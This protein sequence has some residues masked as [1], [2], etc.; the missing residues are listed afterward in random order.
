MKVGSTPYSNIPSIYSKLASKHYSKPVRSTLSSFGN[1]ID[2]TIGNNEVTKDKK[3]VKVG[4]G[5][6]AASTDQQQKKQADL[7]DQIIVDKM[8]KAERQITAH[9]QAHKAVAGQYAGAIS[10]DYETG[11]DGRR[12]VVAGD[13]PINAPQGRTPE[14]TIRIMERVKRAALA[15][16]DPSAQDAAVAARAAQI[17]QAARSEMAKVSN[18]E[19]QKNYFISFPLKGEITKISDY[20]PYSQPIEEPDDEVETLEPGQKKRMG[21]LEKLTKGRQSQINQASLDL[22]SRTAIISEETNKSMGPNMVSYEKHK[23][24]VQEQ[25]NYSSRMFIILDVVA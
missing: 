5:N 17:Q 19:Y 9:E 11:P 10:Y 15:P 4:S 16:A 23:K 25:R 3:S 22:A 12:Y 6:P 24:L 21:V 8:G 2:V 13:V 7:N 14:E 18:Q 20:N 1:L